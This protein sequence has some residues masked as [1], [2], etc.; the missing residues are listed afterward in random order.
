MHAQSKVEE[1]GLCL[2]AVR[3]GGNCFFTWAMWREEE[4]KRKN[5][6][7][8]IKWIC[9]GR[10]GGMQWS[11]GL[12]EMQNASTTPLSTDSTISW[13]A[14]CSDYTMQVAQ[15]GHNRTHQICC[16]LGLLPFFPISLHRQLYLIDWF[17]L[18]WQWRDKKCMCLSYSLL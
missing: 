9:N 11:V 13:S 7:K 14:P 5:T 1:I 10:K 17:L 16:D 6:K 8:F 18:H 15:A 12:I 3:Q 2:Q 4:E